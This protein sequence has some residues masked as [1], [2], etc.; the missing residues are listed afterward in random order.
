MS[1]E[2]ELAQDLRIDR[3]NLHDEWAK[4]PELYNKWA[5]RHVGAIYAQDKAKLKLEVLYGTLDAKVRRHWDTLG[6]DKA[7]TETGISSW[8]KTNPE[9]MALQEQIAANTYYINMFSAARQSLEHKKRALEDIEKLFLS[10]YY[11]QLPFSPTHKQEVEAA[12]REHLN[13]ASGE[14]LLKRKG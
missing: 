3:S 11:G 10:G 8:I 5:S 12:G 14:S 4:Q 2:N 1:Q 9:Y 7:P 6:F 13:A